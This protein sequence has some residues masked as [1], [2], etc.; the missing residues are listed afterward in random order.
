MGV[1]GAVWVLGRWLAAGGDLAA[2]DVDGPLPFLSFEP[3][4][5]RDAEG[6]RW[7]MAGDG[8]QLLA[9]V[10]F[11][12]AWLRARGRRAAGVVLLALVVGARAVV[13]LVEAFGVGA[14]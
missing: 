12:G 1:C 5:P 14:R 3:P 6:A 7:A 11:A 10:V 8:L 4:L 2:D 13:G 9:L